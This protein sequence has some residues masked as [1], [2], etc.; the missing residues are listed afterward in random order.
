MTD[1]NKFFKK[2]DLSDLECN[3]FTM[4]GKDWY[5]L[6]SGTPEA[7]N[8]MTASWGAMGEIWGTP[9][10]HCVVRTNRHTLEYLDQNE[11]FTVT[12][13]DSGYKPALQFC[14]SHSGRDCDKA[15][16]TGLQPVLLDGTTTFAQARRVLICRKVYTAMLQ[17][18][19]FVKPETYER[20]YSSDPMHR[21]FV[22]EVIAYY[23][24]IH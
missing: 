4:I 11:L 12:F 9:S 7:Y 18:D 1:G 6:T 2:M 8:T 23:E 10:F 20:W 15:K 3:P 13:F 17:K 5:L 19:G 22:G 14:G 21:E 16:E 24:R